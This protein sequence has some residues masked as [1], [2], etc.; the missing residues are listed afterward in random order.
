MFWED[1]QPPK[2]IFIDSGYKATFLTYIKADIF[3][4]FSSEEKINLW[5]ITHMDEDHINGIIVF[6]S[7]LKQIEKPEMIEELW[8][9]CFER[10]NL[11]DNSSGKSGIK[12]AIKV[13]E[14]LTEENF[15]AKV[16]DQLTSKVEPVKIG[17]AQL[18]V[19]SP[20]IEGY[21]A[22]AGHWAQ[23][24]E[25]YWE[26]ENKSKSADEDEFPADDAII[27]EELASRK[28]FKEDENDV[29]NRTSIAFL[30]EHPEISVLFLGD[31]HPSLVV[32]AIEQLNKSRGEKLNVDYI[33]L[34]HHG[35]RKN[36]HH[37]LLDVVDCNRFIIS[38][39]GDNCDGL[40][41]KETFAR[42]LSRTDKE[43]KIYFYFNY[44]TARFRKM[45]EV[46]AKELNMY[47]FECVFPEAENATLYIERGTDG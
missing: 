28:Y 41:N 22:L 44:D 6:L 37:S 29:A 47:N 38:S 14:F 33:K 45:F 11:P 5:V 46:D 16:I 40:P 10:L 13:R 12:N 24:E 7:M 18:T 3:T 32:S 1:G 23:L 35:S 39:C 34:S 27:I 26:N 21:T 15:S 4:D 43:K 31:A 20:D 19:L 30:F 9:N 8:F 36:F 25:Y 2:N 17:N 42:I